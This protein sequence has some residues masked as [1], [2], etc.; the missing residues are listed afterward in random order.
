MVNDEKLDYDEDYQGFSGP[1]FFPEV[2]ID[3]LLQEYKSDSDLKKSSVLQYQYG[4]AM[5]L[6]NI[7]LLD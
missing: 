1:E 3:Q 6:L 5:K 7:L 2:E 4:I